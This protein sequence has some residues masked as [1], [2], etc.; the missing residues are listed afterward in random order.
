MHMVRSGQPVMTIELGNRL[1]TIL[2]RRTQT[3][4]ISKTGRGQPIASSMTVHPF[5]PPRNINCHS[6]VSFSPP[7]KLVYSNNANADKADPRAPAPI[8]A[9]LLAPD[10]VLAVADAEATELLAELEVLVAA[11]PLTGGHVPF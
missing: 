10:L 5:F 8:T 6:Q 4:H 9:T 11:V 3:R 7:V 1:R 2:Q